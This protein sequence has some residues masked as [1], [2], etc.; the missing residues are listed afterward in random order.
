VVKKNGRMT[1]LVRDDEVVEKV[2]HHR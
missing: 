1:A 2:S